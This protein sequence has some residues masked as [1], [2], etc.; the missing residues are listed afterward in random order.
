[1]RTLFVIENV[2]LGILC[3]WLLKPRVIQYYLRKKKLRET[4]RVTEIT[5]IVRQY[6]EELSKDG[7]KTK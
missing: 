2:V 5:T 6:L 4:Q 7:G 1:M 3:L